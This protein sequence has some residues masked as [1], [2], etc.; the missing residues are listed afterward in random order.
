MTRFYRDRLAGTPAP[1]AARAAA[2][3]AL[4]ELRQREQP[5]HPYLWAG[6]VTARDWN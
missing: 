3:A 4:R 6:F 2:R 1:D 5:A